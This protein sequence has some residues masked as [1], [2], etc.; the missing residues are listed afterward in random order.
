MRDIRTDTFDGLGGTDGLGE[1]GGDAPPVEAPPAEAPPT[2]PAPPGEVPGTEVPTPNAGGG[3]S[4]ALPTPP[5]PPVYPVPPVPPPPI[6]VGVAGG[7][8]QGGGPAGPSTFA[9]VGSEAAARY[10]TPFFATN[11][12]QSGGNAQPFRFGPGAPTVGGQPA[13]DLGG[14]GGE[15]GGPN[16]DEELARIVQAVAAGRAPGGR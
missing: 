13:I 6:S 1:F 12:I 15:G 4:G 10:R 8:V 9:G 3:A 7:P 5:A 2:A 14:P 16:S 11:R